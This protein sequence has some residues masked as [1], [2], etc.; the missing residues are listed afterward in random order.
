MGQLLGILIADSVQLVHVYFQGR[1]IYP[2]SVREYDPATEL[3]GHPTG[4]LPI[5]KFKEIGSF[6]DKRWVEDK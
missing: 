5:V 1:N 4:I 3:I 2:D 6:N